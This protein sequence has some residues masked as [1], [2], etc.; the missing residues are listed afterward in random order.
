MAG[1]GAAAASTTFDWRLTTEELISH[2]SQEHRLIGRSVP[3]GGPLSQTK[4]D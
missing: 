3:A 2:E 1:G 4:E